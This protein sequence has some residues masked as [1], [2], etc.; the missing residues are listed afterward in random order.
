MR[1]RAREGTEALSGGV[2]DADPDLGVELE[3]QGP[4]ARPLVPPVLPALAAA[5]LVERAVMSAA[6]GWGLGVQ[7][8][9]ALGAA[10]LALA[11]ARAEGAT[12]LALVTGSVALVACLASLQAA[13]GVAAQSRALQGMP[14]SRLS[15]E[16]VTDSSPGTYGYT[17]RARV[18]CPDEGV[19]G[20]V[21]LTSNQPLLLG[22]QVR[23]VG[24]FRPTG[25]DEWGRS[26]RQQGLAGSVRLVLV[27]EVG[28]DTGSLA[29]LHH[30]RRKAIGRLD[31]AGSDGAAIV[32]GA[33]LGYRAG[34]AERGLD[35][36]FSACG[37]SHLVAVSGTH[38]AIVSAL[39]GQ[40]LAWLG[41]GPR[42][43]A[44]V[45]LSLGLAFVLLCGAPA[46]A[47]RAWLMV[48]VAAMAQVRGR[49]AH[50]LS[51]VCLVAL[52]MALAEPAVAGQ[53]GYVLSVLSVVGLSGLSPWVA[54]AMGQ[55]V[56]EPRLPGQVPRR[57][58]VAA[59]RARRELVRGLASTLVAQAA[60]LP[61]TVAAFGTASLVAPL[62][63]VLVAPTFS[64]VV[65]LGVAGL[66][67]SWSPLGGLA[68]AGAQGLAGLVAGAL[69]WMASVPGASVAVDAGPG[70]ALGLWGAG[71]AI[72]V[73]WPRVKPRP[74]RLFLVGVAACLLLVPPLAQALAPP[75]I[76]VL[77]VGQGDAILVQDG[78]SALLVDTGPDASAARDLRQLGVSRLGGVVLTHLH[79]DHVGGLGNIASGMPVGQVY[80]AQGV[81]GGLPDELAQAVGRCGGGGAEELALGDVMRVG[82]FTLTVVWP[83]GEVSGQENADSLELLLTYKDGNESLTALLTGDAE[84]DETDKVL[85][86]G[87]VGDVDL[88]KLGHHG[89]EASVTAEELASL[90]PELV[91][92]S[93]GEGNPY[94]H[95]TQE[96]VDL[97]EGAGATFLCT[98]DVGTVTVEPGTEGPV[99]SV[100]RG[101]E[102]L[103]DVA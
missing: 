70:W 59:L 20:L 65:G 24:R 28:E 30:L 2:A 96:C 94:G 95:P 8:A 14:V 99:V 73:L 21:T 74:L 85:A 16:A 48:A 57:A 34:L 18:T 84:R 32:A 69:G 56:P 51:S 82:R 91:V 37:L 60:T 49:R 7:V 53:L 83:E 88:L 10:G 80:V 17:C 46:S 36:L 5:I 11:S 87:R 40:A 67:L 25:D 81:A 9:L 89:S 33:T 35:D 52:A 90:H 19:D 102:A 45:T 58:R 79:D 12:R 78:M 98:R 31:P 1:V 50:P 41:A 13:A 44:G 27:Q 3:D 93:A 42:L 38:L 29:P 72:L 15:I 55:V 4:P 22:D 75:R 68:L 103:A 23:G 66:A 39:V 43:R 77:D 71:L 64:L 76:C 97:V 86:E 101:G 100:G 54:Y 63:N 92:A 26:Q 61:V 47:V 6:P 62:A